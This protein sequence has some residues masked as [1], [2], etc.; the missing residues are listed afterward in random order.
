MRF[1]RLVKKDAPAQA[2]STPVVLFRDRQTLLPFYGGKCRAC[3]TV[4]YPQH[5]V[6]IEC[7]DRERPRRR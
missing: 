5:R 4:Q 1:R 2:L 7:S 6:C 3:G